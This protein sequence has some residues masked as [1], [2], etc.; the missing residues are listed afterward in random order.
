M[1]QDLFTLRREAKQRS[2]AQWFRA[3]HPKR[4]IQRA[5]VISVG[6]SV[7]VEFKPD[8]VWILHEGSDHGPTQARKGGVQVADGMPVH[9]A[10][11][12]RN[13]DEWQIIDIYYGGLSPGTVVQVVRY[14]V[15]THAPNHQ[16]PSE[17]NIGSDPV[18]VYHPALQPL[19]TTG[20]AATLTVTVQPHTYMYG[21]RPK[22]FLGTTVDLTSSVPGAGLIRRVLIYL[23]E[24]TNTL[25]TVEGATVIDNG[26]L[27]VPYPDLPERGR[28]SA[29]VSLSN[30]QAAVTTATHVVQ[31]TDYLRPFTE[32]ETTTPLTLDMAVVYEGNVVT[33][34]GEIVYIP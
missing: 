25:L 14:Q 11:D 1:P 23:D 28:A 32:T 8:Y 27:P 3:F 20:D 26:V 16:Y 33:L 30:G 34:N 31:V 19:K 29:Y 24:Q 4:N 6:G 10:K 18:L 5:K 2:D 9:V 15:G 22:F 17:A 7:E 12:P 13:P 21:A